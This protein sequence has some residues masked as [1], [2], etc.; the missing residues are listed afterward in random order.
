MINE[1]IPYRRT[2]QNRR[3]SREQNAVRVFMGGNMAFIMQLNSELFSAVTLREPI[4][5]SITK[6]TV[7]GESHGKPSS[8]TKK[9]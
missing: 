5:I 4:T 2:A 6:N 1:L 9:C 8:Y 7:L 3:S